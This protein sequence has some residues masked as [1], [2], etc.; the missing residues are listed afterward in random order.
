MNTDKLKQIAQSPEFSAL[1]GKQTHVMWDNPSQQLS[2]ELTRR[3]VEFAQNEQHRTLLAEAAYAYKNSATAFIADIAAP[4]FAVTA[5]A[6]KYR[7]YNERSFYDQPDTSRGKDSPPARVDIGS[8]MENYDLSGRAL[9]VYMSNVDRDDA[10]N[11]YGSVERWRM[12]L[13]EQL[14]HLLL[15]DREITVA[16]L[17]QADG[18]YASG[19]FTT[20]SPLWSDASANFLLDIQ[21]GEDALL[22]DRDV[23]IMGHNVF[24]QCQ[25]APQITGATTVSGKT[26]QEMRPYVEAAAISAFFDSQVVRGSARYNSTPSATTATL[27]RIWADYVLVLHNGNSIGS[28]DL[29]T[30]FCRTFK[31]QS[32]SFPNVGGFTVKSVMDST[33]LAGGEILMVGYWSDEKI[34]AQKAGYKLKVL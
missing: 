6:G 8:A 7:K 2:S 9:S 24:R 15:I 23:L 28:P 34:F 17:L 12:V 25:R 10:M 1:H 13:T 26:R 19:F 33:T 3:P 22:A 27:S 4:P 21:T 11:Q 31:L 18:S 5:L 32:T 20:A 14:T 30:P 16:T 29:A